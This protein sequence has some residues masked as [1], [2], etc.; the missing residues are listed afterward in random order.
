M[1]YVSIVC[2]AGAAVGLCSPAS[3][4][5]GNALAGGWN[6]QLTSGIKSAAPGPAPVTAPANVSTTVSSGG[7]FSGPAFSFG[8]GGGGS[9]GN[10]GSAPSPEV[11]AT[12][13][14]ILVGGTVAI[15]RRRRARKAGMP[16]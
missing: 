9:G 4:G 15:L 13:S 12:L 3:A 8:S 14:L 7:I 2:L 1:K 5:N 6:G 11:N 10:T 16:A